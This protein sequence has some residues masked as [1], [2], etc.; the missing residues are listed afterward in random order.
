VT[1]VAALDDPLAANPSGDDADVMPPHHDRPDAGP[2]RIAAD[3]SPI[4]REPQPAISNAQM[5]TEPPP[6][7]GARTAAPARDTGARMAPPKVRT[8][9]MYV[10]AA[11]VMTHMNV[12]GAMAGKV[13]FVGTRIG[14]G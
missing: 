3:R 1:V 8:M 5:M 7:P 14:V 12:V 9:T 11:H 2:A 4:A 13:M 10:V 6:A